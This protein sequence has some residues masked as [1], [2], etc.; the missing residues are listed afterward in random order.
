[1]AILL[2]DLTAATMQGGYGLLPDAAIVMDGAIRWIGPRAFTI[3]RWF[4]KHEHLQRTQDFYERYGGKTIVLARFVPIIR[5]FAPFLAGVGKMRYGEFAL[6]NVT[7]A[8]AWVVLGVYAG[9][10]FSEMEIGGKK[11]I[12]E[13]FSLVLIAIVVISLLPAVIE[14][15]RARKHALPAT[16]DSDA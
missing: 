9:Y 1:M 11:V 3:D 5:T 16:P 10:F 4:L 2:T 8:V 7:G 14:Y 13:N 6:Y 12:K 15:W